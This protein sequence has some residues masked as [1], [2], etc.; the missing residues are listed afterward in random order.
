M[1]VGGATG[2]ELE[3]EFLKAE[4]EG[5]IHSLSVLFDSRDLQEGI[6]QVEVG[7]FG[8]VEEEHDDNVEQWN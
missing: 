3:L 1:K 6:V 5:E 7:E 8:T 2:E 4:E